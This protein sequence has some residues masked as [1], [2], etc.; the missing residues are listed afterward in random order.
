MASASPLAAPPEPGRV[1]VPDANFTFAAALVD[2]LADSGVHHV[3]VCPGSRSAPLAAAVARAGRLPWSV[4]IDERSAGFFA[5]GL[6]RALRRPVGLV[7]SSGTAA[8][9]LCPAVVEAHHAR[10][11]LLLLTADRPP[12]LRDFGAPQTIRQPGLFREHVRFEADAAT[13]DASGAGAAYARALGARAVA[14]ATGPPAGPVHLNLP[15]REPLHPT[16][17][18]SLVPS[19]DPVGGDGPRRHVRGPRLLERTEVDDLTAWVAGGPGVVVAGP[20]D[21]GPLLA[22]AVGAFARASGWPV[23][24]EATSGLRAGWAC[25]GLAPAHHPESLA[26]VARARPELRPPRVLQIGAVPTGR[27]LQ[28]LPGLARE[29]SVLVDG[30]DRTADPGHRAW[31][32]VGADPARLLAK[33]AARLSPPGVPEP[34]TRAFEAKVVAAGAAAEAAVARHLARPAGMNEPLA[35]RLLARALPDGAALFAS[36]SLPVRACD[37]WLPPRPGPLRVLANR[38]A[39]GIDGIPSSALG[40]AEAGCHRP[41]VLVS[42]DVALAHDLGGLAALR[43]LAHLRLVAIVFDNGGGGI[44]DRLPIA[45]L[46]EAVD[47]ERCFRA[48]PE[49]PLEAV[50]AVAGMA[51]AEVHGPGA[52]QDA[53]H[54]S[55]RRAVAEPGA[56]TLIRVPIEPAESLAVQRALEAAADAAIAAALDG[57]AGEVRR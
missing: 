53:L 30:E 27:A 44:F 5:L 40:V 54:R 12:E 28:A 38:G 4:H 2:A 45:A 52:L 26:R 50:A 16:D 46:G 13:P 10:V 29:G 41:V 25:S 57:A 49:L 15:C 39:N 9:N 33:L 31:R 21:A 1:A 11:P 42:G 37:A 3:C 7:C 14:E 51:F 23:L 6:A 8:A 56:S 36:N 55:L 34:R 19:P 24:A 20:L 22:R 47:F 48:S 32:V 17:V 43:R 35:I 18:G